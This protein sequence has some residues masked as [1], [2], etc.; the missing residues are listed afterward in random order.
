MMKEELLH[1][2]IKNN[3][4]LFGKFTLPSEKITDYYI[5]IRNTISSP[6]V[7]KL[8]SKLIQKKTKDINFDKIATLGLWATVIATAISLETQK[9]LV[10]IST[11]RNKE[12]I[13]GNINPKDRLILI[14]DITTTG[15]TVL[16]VIKMLENLKTYVTAV[17]VIVD[18]EEGAKEKI[19]RKGY[20]F[21]SL[22][23]TTEILN[24]KRDSTS[25]THKA[26]ER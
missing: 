16:G 20:P 25:D 24:A 8:I 5:D 11:E 23:T 1:E 13:I 12:P 18:R 4:I 22:I 7:L 19:E 17:I 15:D 21:I 9:P 6:H 26:T 3:C 2:M 10:I 14:H